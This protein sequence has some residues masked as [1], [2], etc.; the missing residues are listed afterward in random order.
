MM[1]FVERATATKLPSDEI[2]I[3]PTGATSTDTSDSVFERNDGSQHSVWIQ[4]K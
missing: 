3:L 4:L 1:R 2:A